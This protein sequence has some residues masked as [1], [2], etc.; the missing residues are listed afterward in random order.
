M[1]KIM[2]L[3]LWVLAFIPLI[4][5]N[6]IFAPENSNFFMRSVLVLITIFFLI[7][8]F[9]SSYF[10]EV[11]VKKI[12]FFIKN[13]I[14]ISI[15]AFLSIF[16]ISTI[17]SIDKY[18]AFWGTM[19]RAEGLVGLVYLFSFFTF[20]LFIFEKKDWLWFFKLSLFVSFIIIFKEF[21]QF[22]SGVD[23]PGSFFNNPTFLAG[24]LLFSIFCSIVIFSEIKN[25]FFKYFSVLILILSILGIFITGTRGT[26]VGLA[27]G[28]IVVFI[29]SI[30]KGRSISF[31]NFNLRKV[32]IIIL[33]FIFLFGA[34][35]VTTRQNKV[36]QKVPG[37][38][39]IAL[40][41][42]KDDTTQTRLIMARLS[43]QSINPKEEGI[44]KFLIGWGPENFSL[45]YGKYFNSKQFQY[46]AGWFD[47]SHNKLFDLLVMTGVFGLLT[48][49]SI[50]FFFF[51]SIFK[52]KDFSLLNVGLLLFG[53]SLLVHLLFVFDQITT[54]IFFFGLLSFSIYLTIDNISENIIKKQKSKDKIINKLTIFSG[55]FFLFL[56]LFLYFVFFSND[57]PS[58]RQ[59]KEY[60]SLRKGNYPDV[61]LN[62]IDRVMSPFTLA[63]M[64]IRYDFLF[65]MTKNYNPK[66]DIMVKLSD[67]AFS[68]AEEYIK[69][70]P[71][72][73]QFL[74]ILAYNYNN[75]GKDFNNPEF[76]KK[77]EEYLR[78]LLL[79]AP[80][81]PDFNYVLALNLFYQKRYNESFNLAE[82]LFDK[83]PEYF[84]Q[85]NT[86]KAE[87]FYILFIKH[88]YE[89][90]DKDNF[91]K[92]TKR[93]KDNEYVD[94]ATLDQII[95]FIN[96]TGVWPNINFG[97]KE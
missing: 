13:P 59:I 6:T 65:F 71:L 35:F 78:T 34:F 33:C 43:L 11:I 77:S 52:I 66:D 85:N 47:R 18:S 22:F 40:I 82:N 37:L 64:S 56:I 90:K 55:I 31:L 8:F 89:V 1:I 48:Y 2:K 23:R 5:D 73:L 4:V 45:A 49:L 7:N 20:S 74:S 58:F 60:D 70:V 81:R 26:L 32:L 39:R 53:S 76:I 50:Y 95:E 67:L 63:Q 80:N 72:D 51:K 91:I 38:S 88:F 69:R 87:W 92:A 9:Y 30:I 27:V 42:G 19:G 79:M 61:I 97:E 12:S 28:I 21:F 75:Q 62:K 10:R 83:N 96:K 57:L 94:S 17:F 25:N 24:Y 15:L 36:W 46:E 29:Y 41:S 14:V 93:L 68:K 54:S 84:S 3:C 16:I 86:G 44:K